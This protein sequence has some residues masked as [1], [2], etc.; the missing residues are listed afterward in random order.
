[1]ATTTTVHIQ[2]L[3]GNEYVAA[4]DMLAQEEPLEIR[5]LYGPDRTTKSISVT[6]RTPGNDPELS[7]GFLYTE[8]IITN[9]NQVEK[10]YNTLVDEN[11]VCVEL[12]PEVELK[13]SSLERNFYTTSSCGVCG[14]SSID[15][16]KTNCRIELTNT[17]NKPIDPEVIYKLP[18]TLRQQQDI[19]ESTGGL[20]ASALFDLEGNTIVLREDVGRHN[21]LDKLIGY[22][23]K[24]N[25]LPLENYI[26]LLSGRASFELIQKA[27]MAGIRVVAAIGAP[28]S[29]AVD[30]A[31][32]SGMTL[33][34]FLRDNRM[35][36][37]CGSERISAVNL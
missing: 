31:K 21:A 19:F 15:A 10:A 32:E 3:S 30:L 16:I 24:E 5:I 29:L 17:I 23:L 14:K 27:M 4:D 28:S 33:V 2:K 37:Y 25:L 7:T 1:M 36:I 20:H 35:N 12:K 8:G 34:G 11:I 13:L 26:L 18:T 22:C 6:M 9:Y